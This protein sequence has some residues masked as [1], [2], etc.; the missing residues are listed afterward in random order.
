MNYENFLFETVE[1]LKASA[2]AEGLVFEVRDV[3][4]LQ[5]ESYKGLS[6]HYPGAKVNVCMNLMPFYEQF[7]AGQDRE[8]VMEDVRKAVRSALE[9]LKTKDDDFVLPDYEEAKNHLMLELISKKT[10]DA[11][12]SGIPYQEI[13]D[14]ALIYRLD[15]GE[16]EGSKASAVINSALLKQLGV[17]ADQIHADAMATVP[18]NSPMRIRPMYEVLS[19]ISGMNMDPG[20][21]APPLFVA[22]NDSGFM[23]AS[24]LAYP[25]FGEKASALLGDDFYIIPSS[26]HELL[27]MP[28]HVIDPA[29]L[30]YIVMAVNRQEVAPEDRLSD[31]VYFYSRSTGQVT[32]AEEEKE[33][34]TPIIF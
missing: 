22:T 16:T 3:E 33:K 32:L 10:N 12:L 24:V 31:N 26:I 13:A 34:E 8:S 20:P 15:F 25:D 1:E 2:G 19:E 7:D 14:L 11:R 4:K 29:T 23:G 5:G 27:L 9:R 30:K 28:V 18:V 6:I 21:G 17:G